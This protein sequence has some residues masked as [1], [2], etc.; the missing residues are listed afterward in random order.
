MG[1]KMDDANTFDWMKVVLQNDYIYTHKTMRFL[2][3]AYDTHRGEDTIHVGTPQCNIMFLNGGWSKDSDEPPYLYAKVLGIF[4]TNVLYAG[5]LPGGKFEHAYRHINVVWVRWHDSLSH[6]EALKLDRVSLHPL[7]SREALDF[8][9]PAYA[10]R[11]LHITPR[12]AEGKVNN[13]TPPSMLVNEGQLWKEYY[14]NRYGIL[15]SFL[16]WLTLGT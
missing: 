9:D 3:T 6:A 12:F 7:R 10:V 2:Y 16:H 4:H 5:P 15:L 14:V 11:A 1:L 13:L 8:V